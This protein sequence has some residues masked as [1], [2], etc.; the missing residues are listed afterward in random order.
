[1]EGKRRPS[2]VESGNVVPE[3]ERRKH[4]GHHDVAKPENGGRPI[5]VFE[6]A[7]SRSGP[8]KQRGGPSR[9]DKPER[10]IDAGRHGLH[11]GRAKHKV[12]VVDEKRRKQKQRRAERAGAD[13]A[14]AADGK[15]ASDRVVDEPV[16]PRKAVRRESRVVRIEKRQQRHSGRKCN[17][18]TP[19][20]NHRRCAVR[21]SRPEHPHAVVAA[22]PVLV[23]SEIAQFG[24]EFSLVHVLG[25]AQG[26][27]V[28]AGDAKPQAAEEEA[29]V[30]RKATGVGHVAQ[31]DT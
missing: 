30:A 27:T 6:R 20:H 2:P 17:G 18:E 13:S 11:G 26:Q 1:M 9:E 15:N 10:R 8:R 3:T 23:G 31:Q 21:S 5:Q 19:V 12:D 28:L 25:H 14:A 22:H 24:V 16:E 7:Q 4:A 29:Q